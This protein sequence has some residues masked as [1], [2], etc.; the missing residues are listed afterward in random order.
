[1]DNANTPFNGLTEN[2]YQGQNKVTLIEAMSEHGFSDPRFMTYDQAKEMGRFV[3]RGQK[4]AAR[5]QGKG[6][7]YPV[8]NFEQTRA[9]GEKAA[10]KPPVEVPFDYDNDDGCS[11]PAFEDNDPAPGDWS[12]DNYAPF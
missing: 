10:P 12:N 2:K 1:M 9:P 6:R 3:M 5:L 4:A 11:D 8:F 7:P